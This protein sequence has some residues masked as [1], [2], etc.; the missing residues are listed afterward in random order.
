[1]KSLHH[2]KSL[3]AFV[4]LLCPFCLF[5]QVTG[6]GSRMNEV[7]KVT[8]LTH[9]TPSSTRFYDPWEVTYGPDD[10]LWVTEAKNYKVYK[11]STNGGTPRTILDISPG[12]TF[13]P[14]ADQV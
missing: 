12:S 9:G 14:S 6:I 13:L 7:F 3:L 8:E 11:I 10:S 5:S 1:M 4:L 2:S